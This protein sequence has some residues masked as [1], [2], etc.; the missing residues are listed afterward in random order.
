MSNCVPLV[1]DEV[2]DLLAADQDGKPEDENLKAVDEVLADL[3]PSGP[4]L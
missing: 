2:V 3:Y 1:K 4:V